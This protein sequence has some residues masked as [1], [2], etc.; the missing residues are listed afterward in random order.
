MK[1]IIK[2][3]I[4]AAR[5]RTLPLAFSG[6]ILAIF[7]A[8][9]QGVFKLDIFILAII[10]TLLLQILSN[11]ANDYGDY[12]H[13]TDNENRVGPARTL[14]SGAISPKAMKIAMYITG[15]LAFIFGISLLFVALDQILNP[16]FI[17]FLLLGIAAIG[18][19]IKYTVGKNNFGYV[20]LGDVMVF[21]F[22]GIAAVWGTYFL[23]ALT[24]DWPVLLPAAAIGFLSSGVLNVNNMRDI[25][26]DKA[27]GKNTVAV[28]LGVMQSKMY[29]AFL[30]IGSLF[31]FIVYTNILAKPFI[32]LSL[33]LPY[34]L[35]FLHLLKVLKTKTQ[36]ELDPELKRL[37]LTTLLIAFWLGIG[38]IL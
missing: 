20:G 2:T 5:L 8:Y 14:Q 30:I 33:F 37:S 4:K 38:L 28:R 35:L 36:K 3:W 19:A 22:F 18:A 31:L 15:T 17:L 27:S 29:H 21:I 1:R 23:M 32:G 13:G 11:F 24:M 7:I 34:T 26:N 12:S 9:S 6:I 16:I 25:D 10:T